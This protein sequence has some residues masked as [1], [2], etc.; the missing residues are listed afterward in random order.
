MTPRAVLLVPTPE[1][2]EALLR[3]GPCG[4]RPPTAWAHERRL[5]VTWLAGH[6]G[7]MPSETNALVLV[8]DGAPVPEGCDRAARVLVRHLGASDAD[9]VAWHHSHRGY[10]ELWAL[11]PRVQGGGMGWRSRNFLPYGDV[12]E[13]DPRNCPEINYAAPYLA[14]PGPTWAPKAIED[15]AEALARVCAARGLGTVVTIGGAS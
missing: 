4:A 12:R 10:W 6:S 5:G 9:G 3:E 15:R 14:V 13:A 2:R 8:W 11:W 7:V 1:W